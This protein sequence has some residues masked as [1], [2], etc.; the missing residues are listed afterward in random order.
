MYLGIVLGPASLQHTWAAADAKY[1]E[2]LWAIRT[3]GL[4]AALSAPLSARG[5]GA[6]GVGYGMQALPTRGYSRLLRVTQLPAAIRCALL[7]LWVSSAC[8]AG[9]FQV[10]ML[11]RLCSLGRDRIAHR[12][13]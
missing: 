12:A 13:R 2:R 4:G 7:R 5:R 9:R 11:C 1:E 6:F 10:R 8:T 3:L